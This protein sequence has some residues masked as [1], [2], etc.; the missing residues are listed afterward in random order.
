[1]GVC[2]DVM[3]CVGGWCFDYLQIALVILLSANSEMDNQ[4]ETP[5]I[6]SMTPAS[7]RG[8]FYRQS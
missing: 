5:H 1:M 3:L 6:P 2:V 4:G 7:L 8:I